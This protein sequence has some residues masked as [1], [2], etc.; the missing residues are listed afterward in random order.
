MDT[1]AKKIGQNEGTKLILQ[2]MKAFP[3]CIR[4]QVD[5]SACLA[6]MASVETNRASM[7]EDGCIQQ[8]LENMSRFM[9]QPDVQTELFATLANLSSH[10]NF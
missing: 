9:S 10:G 8:V 3:A 1:L 5:S 7:L 6:N 2:I 4:I